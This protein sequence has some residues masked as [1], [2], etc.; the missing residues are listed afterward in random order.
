[1]TAWLRNVRF[2]LLLADIHRQALDVRQ[3][4][5]ADSCMLRASCAFAKPWRLIEHPGIVRGRSRA[6]QSSRQVYFED[7]MTRP[8][9]LH[10]LLQEVQR[11][12]ERIVSFPE[13]VRISR[14]IESEEA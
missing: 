9:I 7:E 3:V 10:W 4:P 8:R 2:A 11:M 5:K 6:Q 13:L 1:M 12:A 14:G